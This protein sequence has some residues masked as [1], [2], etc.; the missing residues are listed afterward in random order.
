MTSTIVVFANMDPPAA[1]VVAQSIAKVL[2]KALPGGTRVL[3]R[4]GG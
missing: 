4:L 2:G 3:R 1:T